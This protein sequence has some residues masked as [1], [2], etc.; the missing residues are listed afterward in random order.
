MSQA[1]A[2]IICRSGDVAHDFPDIGMQMAH[3]L[4]QEFDSESLRIILC[5]LGCAIDKDNVP[6]APTTDNNNDR[7][8]TSVQRVQSCFH[9]LNSLDEL[10][11]LLQ[12]ITRED[13]EEEYKEEDG[14]L[15][16]LINLTAFVDPES[17]HQLS[18][19]SNYEFTRN[20]TDR[21]S[22]LMK[23]NGQVILLSRPVTLFHLMEQGGPLCRQAK[24]RLLSAN[25]RRADVDDFVSKYRQQDIHLKSLNEETL[26]HILIMCYTLILR[27]ELYQEPCRRNVEV[28]CLAYGRDRDARSLAKMLLNS[29]TTT[30]D[31][32]DAE[33]DVSPDALSCYGS[34]D[35]LA[36]ID[37]RNKLRLITWILS[38]LG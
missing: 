19:T 37:S 8:Q 23:R 22:P 35:S 27:Q 5:S 25:V 4:E 17:G 12:E 9:R 1:V 14:C 10:L 38:Y 6:I 13:D 30:D 16:L 33:C 24:D 21:L 11:H 2:L 36:S 32:G 15:D 3:Q 29:C 26:S 18:I 34:Y 31:D 20:L 28:T 7:R